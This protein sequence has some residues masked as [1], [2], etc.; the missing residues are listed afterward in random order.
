MSGVCFLTF[1]LSAVAVGLLAS[2]KEKQ[3]GFWLATASTFLSATFPV[4]APLALETEAR[5][6][7]A[8]AAAAAV[9]ATPAV[10]PAGP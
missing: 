5:A 7:K 6:A 8:P 3:Y 4:A 1:V 10:P 2:G 9:A